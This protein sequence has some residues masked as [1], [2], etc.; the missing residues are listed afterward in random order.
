VP[1]PK[2]ASGDCAPWHG[3][4]V[5][6]RLTTLE[7][8]ENVAHVSL[9]TCRLA[10]GQ[11]PRAVMLAHAPCPPWPSGPPVAEGA[12]SRTAQCSV[13]PLAGLQPACSGPE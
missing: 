3:R 10:R 2:S 7:N 1:R 11:H 6:I 8:A 5:E 9:Q 4:R 12:S 13:F